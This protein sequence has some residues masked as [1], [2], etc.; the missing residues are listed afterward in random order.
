MR[1]KLKYLETFDWS[2]MAKYHVVPR[3]PGKKKRG[4]TGLRVCFVRGGVT[5]TRSTRYTCFVTTKGAMVLRPRTATLLSLAATLA[6]CS[7]SSDLETDRPITAATAR[8][9]D[10][11]IDLYASSL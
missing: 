2:C 10:A 3:D 4:W 8:G 1:I 6:A 5:R 11:P 9:L 7:V